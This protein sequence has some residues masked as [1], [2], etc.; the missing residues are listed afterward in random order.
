MYSF[1]PLGRD[2]LVVSGYLYK[3]VSLCFV[4]FHYVYSFSM[5]PSYLIEL[6]ESCTVLAVCAASLG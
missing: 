1:F 5:I 2:H 6:V 4:F 3:V